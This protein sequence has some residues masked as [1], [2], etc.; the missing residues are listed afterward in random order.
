MEFERDDG[1][2]AFIDYTLEPY[3]PGVSFGP[4]EICYPPE[5]G[6]V[7][8]SEATSDGVT[9]IEMTDAEWE[10]ADKEIEAQLSCCG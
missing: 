8:E 9:I 4:A 10:R 7:N 3:D 1:S 6:G 2:T 5:G